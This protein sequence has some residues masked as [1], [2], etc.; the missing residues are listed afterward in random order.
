MALSLDTRRRKGDEGFT[1][2]ELLIV[3]IILGVLAAIVVF[4]VKGIVDRGDTAACQQN[5]S[6]AETA[7]E[8][9]YAKKGSYPATL[10]AMT[11]GADKF[12]H[13][14]PSAATVDAKIRVSYD[15][16]TGV[17]TGGTAC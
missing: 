2:I 6:T 11:S 10:A 9:Y 8:A 3:I 1:L 4:S 16:A 15:S 13:S 17:V 12:L 5:R 7:V 14:D